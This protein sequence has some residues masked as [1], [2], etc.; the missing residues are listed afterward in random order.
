MRH[1]IATAGGD[2]AQGVDPPCQSTVTP[3]QGASVTRMLAPAAVH[4]CEALNVILQLAQVGR[5]QL[6]MLTC[7]ERCAERLQI[8]LACAIKLPLC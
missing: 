5:R 4:D 7:R 8:A 3:P 1:Y 6:R 2:R